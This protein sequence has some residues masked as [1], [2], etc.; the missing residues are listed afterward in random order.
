MSKDQS[1]FRDS[2]SKSCADAVSYHT[3]SALPK[4]VDKL[5]YAPI[6]HR[7]INTE[8][9]DA[10]TD[11]LDSKRTIEEILKQEQRQ[12]LTFQQTILLIIEYLHFMNEPRTENDIRRKVLSKHNLRG[13]ISTGIYSTYADQRLGFAKELQSVDRISLN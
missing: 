11:R 5:H 12:K 7:F 10:L 8:P 2:F 4:R 1:N 3:E 6:D 9:Q 13:G